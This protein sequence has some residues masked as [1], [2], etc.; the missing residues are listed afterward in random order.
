MKN[1]QG[2]TGEQLFQLSKSSL[3]RLTEKSESDRLYDLLIQQKQLSGVTKNKTL[4]S[5]HRFSCSS[6][7][8]RS[9]IVWNV[10]QDWTR[11]I[12]HRSSRTLYVTLTV[13]DFDSNFSAFQRVSFSFRHVF[14]ATERQFESIVENQIE[15]TTWQNRTSRKCCSN[16]RLGWKFSFFLFLLQVFVQISMNSFSK[17]FNFSWN[18]SFDHKR[19]W[20]RKKRTV[21]V[22]QTENMIDNKKPKIISF[23]FTSYFPFFFVYG[24]LNVG[25]FCIM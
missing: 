23:L 4:Y 12:L 14:Y 7:S 19:E 15:T 13:L 22:K 9:P 24:F 1:L 16:W 20:H 2:F 17:C 10:L 3:D 11:P 6:F 25:I 18:F 21:S 8:I 5:T